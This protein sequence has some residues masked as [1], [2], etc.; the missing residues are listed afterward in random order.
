MVGPRYV[1]AEWLAYP[2][3]DPAYQGAGDATGDAYATTKLCNILCA[4]ELDRRLQAN[5]LSTAERPI[6]VN[7]F[8]PGLVAGTGL[9]RPVNQTNRRG[10]TQ[11]CP[12][13]DA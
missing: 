6:M 5:I 8:N 2:E 7:A 9:G 3:R 10:R 13:T 1:K 11:E 12:R 4:Y